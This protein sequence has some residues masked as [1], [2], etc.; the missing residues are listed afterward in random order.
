MEDTTCKVGSIFYILN[1]FLCK[2]HIEIAYIS[3]IFLR[4]KIHILK[5]VSIYK[6]KVLKYLMPRFI[7]VNSGYFTKQFHLNKLQWN[8]KFSFP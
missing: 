7:L 1:F 8:Q 6:T 2:K 3:G 5:I 4:K